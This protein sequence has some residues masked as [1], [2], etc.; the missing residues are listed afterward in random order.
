MTG[1]YLFLCVV[2]PGFDSKSPAFLRSRASQAAGSDGR[3][4]KKRNRAPISG[5]RGCVYTICADV[6]SI[7]TACWLCLFGTMVDIPLVHLSATLVVQY[8]TESS[9]G[10]HILNDS[11]EVTILGGFI[12]LLNQ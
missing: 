3:L 12:K 5:G 7:P 4:A 9:A 1:V 2:G 8:H 6:C 11:T 10:H